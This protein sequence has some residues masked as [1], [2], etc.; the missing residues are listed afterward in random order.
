MEAVFESIRRADAAIALWLNGWVGRFPALDA[1]VRVLVSDYFVPVLCVLALVGLWFV[2]RTPAERERYQRVAVLGLLSLLFANM[3]VY[4]LN[5]LIFRP[6]PFADHAMNLLFYQP[7]DSS[8]PANPAAVGF[9][10][11]TAVWHANR[12]LGVL[13]LLAAA[14][15]G[16][17]RMYAGVCYPTDVIAG[18]AIGVGMVFVGRGFL[19]LAEPIPTFTLKALR[20]FHLA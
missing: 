2:G 7:T 3:V 16:V 1:A 14:V 17:A 18:G 15:F 8:F 13:T 4:A 9:A 19:R 12:R 20:L 6:R 5:E 11:A 10:M